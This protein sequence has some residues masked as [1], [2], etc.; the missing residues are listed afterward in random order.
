E[1]QDKDPQLTDQHVQGVV[2]N[3]V[4]AAF[5]TTKATLCGFFLMMMYY[6]EVQKKIQLELDEKIGRDRHPSLDDRPELHYTNA[7]ILEVLRY[8]RHTPLAIPHMTTK[9]LEVEGYRIPSHSTV[10]MNIWVMNRDES[11][12]TDPYSFK[13]ER[14]LDEEGK[15]VPIDHRLRQQFMVFGIGRRNCVGESFA[16]SRVFLYVTSL[17]QKFNFKPGDNELSPENS[18][19]W[20]KKSAL[21]PEFLDCV[22]ENRK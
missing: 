13:P 15:F 2:R 5:V 12:W 16:K 17:L 4:V 22:V 20:L 9:D 6:P 1:E 21:C 3:T 11:I 10:I 7:V 8:I 19:L 18:E 14:F